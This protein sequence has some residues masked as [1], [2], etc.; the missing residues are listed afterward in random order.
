MAAVPKYIDG[1]QPWGDFGVER[2]GYQRNT[3]WCLTIYLLAILAFDS[4]LP[5]PTD[6]SL[7]SVTTQLFCWFN[8]FLFVIRQYP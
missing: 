8:L 4:L 3:R 6:D 1:R 2:V 5:I 7:L